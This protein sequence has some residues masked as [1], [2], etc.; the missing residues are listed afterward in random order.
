MNGVGGV[1]RNKTMR[2]QLPGGAQVGVV[3]KA[4]SGRGIVKPAG[5]CDQGLEVGT[6]KGSPLE[7]GLGQQS[8]HGLIFI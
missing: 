3:C 8:M 7:A 4:S 2:E 6:P 5:L 1:Q